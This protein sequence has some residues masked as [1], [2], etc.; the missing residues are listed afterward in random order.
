MQR[1]VID[2]NAFEYFRFIAVD[3]K[4]RYEDG[5]PTDEQETNRDGEPLF[6]VTVIAKEKGASKPETITVKVPSSKPITIPE[7]AAIGFVNLSAF[8]WCSNNRANLSFSADKVGQ[9]KEQ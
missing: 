6:N 9:L 5:K 1:V 3:P 2:Q 4:M 8:A 7:F